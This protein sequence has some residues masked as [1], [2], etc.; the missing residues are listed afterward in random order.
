MRAT[1][2]ALL[3]LALLLVVGCGKSESED[4]AEDSKEPQPLTFETIIAELEQHPS[5]HRSFLE[6]LT[7]RINGGFVEIRYNSI[8]IARKSEGDGGLNILRAQG[9]VRNKMKTVLRLTSAME[10]VKDV[11]VINDADR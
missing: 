7:F 9:A 10:G 4:R 5:L 11:N 1:T 6:Q 2:Q 8:E 3:A